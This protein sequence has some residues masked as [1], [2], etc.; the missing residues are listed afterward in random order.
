MNTHQIRAGQCFDKANGERVRVMIVSGRGR[1]VTVV[2]CQIITQTIP[3]RLLGTV[4]YTE[5]EYLVAKGAR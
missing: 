4:T 3:C 5:A 1:D 2:E